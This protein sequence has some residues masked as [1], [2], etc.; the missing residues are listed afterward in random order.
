MYC[1]SKSS[2]KAYEESAFILIEKLKK[3]RSMDFINTT[4]PVEL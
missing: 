3:K 4:G 2:Q 1:L